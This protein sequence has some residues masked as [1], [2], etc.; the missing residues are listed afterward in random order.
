M[1]EF[2]IGL[3]IC[4]GA[5]L[6]ISEVQVQTERIRRASQG[7]QSAQYSALMAMQVLDLSAKKSGFGVN[8]PTF[9]GSTIHF[10]NP[11]SNALDSDTLSPVLISTDGDNSRVR[12]MWSTTNANVVPLRLLS[13]KTATTNSVQISNTFG[14][15]IGDLVLYAEPGLDSSI[16]QVSSIVPVNEEL[17]HATS[18]VYPWNNN[19]SSVYPSGG[20]STDARVM[21]LG[22]WERQEFRVEDDQL[23]LRR[24]TTAGVSDALLAQNIVRMV[25]FYGLDNGTGGSAA[26][27]GVP[28]SW[29]NTTP[30]SSADWA[31][32]VALRFV[33]VAKNAAKDKSVV[34]TAAPS[35]SGGSFDLSATP[36]WNHYRYR[37]YEATVPL[38]N[39]V[40][41]APAA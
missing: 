39:A 14:F 36:D 29:S 11:A 31:R 15:N 18:S 37:V 7:G 22:A 13:P 10:Y 34:T 30:T 2:I 12:F 3:L 38:K 40:W 33:V 19:L 20:Y 4:L 24:Q 16:H 26:D 27:D 1:V 21:N 32:V 25:A 35:W 17:G 41:T 5:I 28:D 8:T 23:W 9:L 6:V